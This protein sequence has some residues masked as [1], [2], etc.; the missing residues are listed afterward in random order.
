MKSRT[1]SDIL[2]SEFQILG[3]LKACSATAQGR[4]RHRQVPSATLGMRKTR[5]AL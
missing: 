1:D 3:M 4:V 2:N 5:P